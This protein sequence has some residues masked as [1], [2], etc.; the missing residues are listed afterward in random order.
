MII[1]SLDAY[2]KWNKHKMQNTF[3]SEYS[4]LIITAIRAKKNGQAS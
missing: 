4:I 2:E 1:K 3:T